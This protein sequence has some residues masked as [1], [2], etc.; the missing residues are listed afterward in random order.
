MKIRAGFTRTALARPAFIVA[1]LSA[2]LAAAPVP[3][4][5]GG[6]FGASRA[7]SAPPVFVIDASGFVTT[8]PGSAR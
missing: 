8:R 4:A 6:T 5:D 1:L 2:L 7:S 3:A